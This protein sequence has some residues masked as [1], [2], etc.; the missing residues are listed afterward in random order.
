MWVS[1]P[2]SLPSARTVRTWGLAPQCGGGRL[3]RVRPLH[4]RGQTLPLLPGPTSGR[5]SRSPPALLCTFPWWSTPLPVS[6]LP[7]VTVPRNPEKLLI[8]SRLRAGLGHFGICPNCLNLL[9]WRN[10]TPFCR[11]LGLWR[12]VRKH[13]IEAVVI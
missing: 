8:P 6:T 4:T 13:H 7:R 2:R 11:E 3:A 12:L 1:V 9:G 10:G 5:S